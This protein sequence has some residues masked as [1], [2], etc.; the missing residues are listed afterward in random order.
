MY[1]T[2]GWAYTVVGCDVLDNPKFLGF[3]E[4]HDEALRL[5]KSAEL[6][7]WHSVAV[8][9]AVDAHPIWALLSE[10]LPEL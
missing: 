1:R 5:Q 8:V 3:Y 6:L 2:E 9:S 10:P 4:N 7:G